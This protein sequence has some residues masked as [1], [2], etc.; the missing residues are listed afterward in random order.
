MKKSSD[1]K[2]LQ[3][4]IEAQKKRIVR[5]KS[6]KDKYSIPVAGKEIIM[7]PKVFYPGRDTILM[8]ETVRFRKGDVVL[9]S[10]AGPG[11]FAIFAA[12][13]ANKVIA[14]DVSEYA[15]ANIRENAKHHGLE[16]KVLAVQ[17]DLF[18]KSDMKFD[19][20]LINP[21]YT[22]NKPNDVVERSVWDEGNKTTRKFFKKVKNHLKKNGK[23]YLSWSNFADYNFVEQLAKDSGF[24]IKQ[25][26]EAPEGERQ[27]RIYELRSNKVNSKY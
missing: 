21:P 15:V 18:P 24:Q 26:S 16:D 2:L 10:C 11:A 9:D 14:V 23:I 7:L 1:N 13:K 20:I 27:Y 3:S 12:D 22:D 17:G 19:K 4:T 25:L 6:R 8:L 5:M